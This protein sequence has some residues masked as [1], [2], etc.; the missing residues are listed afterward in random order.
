M[1]S[2]DDVVV[3][4]NSQFLACQPDDYRKTFTKQSSLEFEKNLKSQAIREGYEL[5]K[6]TG[7]K[8]N[9]IYFECSR[10]GLPR[11]QQGTG[12]RARKSKKIS[13]LLFLHLTDIL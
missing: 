2:Q 7:T 9:S 10:A 8:T 6:P 5:I 4:N 13:T 12:K 11:E 3:D 1:D